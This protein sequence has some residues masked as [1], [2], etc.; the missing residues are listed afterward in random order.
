MLYIGDMMRFIK[1][2]SFVNAILPKIGIRYKIINGKVIIMGFY[3]RIK[4][5]N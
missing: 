1:K 2:I 5:K 3:K 4:F